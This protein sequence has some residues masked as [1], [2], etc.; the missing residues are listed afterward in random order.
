MWVKGWEQTV[1]CRKFLFNLTDAAAVQAVGQVIS[2]RFHLFSLCFFL[3]Y[4]MVLV[5]FISV[6]IGSGFKFKWVSGSGSRQ[7]IIVPEKE[8]ERIMFAE[9]SVGLDAFPGACMSF[10]GCLRRHLRRFL[11]KLIF[12]CH[13][14]LSVSGFRIQLQPGSGSG[15]SKM[16]GSGSWFS[17]SLSGFSESR[18]E[19]LIFVVGWGR[20]GVGWGGVGWGG[21]GWGG[22]GWG[23]EGYRSEIGRTVLKL[24]W[25]YGDTNSKIPCYFFH[26]KW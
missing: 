7:A 2:Q 15:F 21:V 11:I 16:S 20:V 22:V 12:H 19:T 17:E 6:L 25:F 5:Y 18:Y 26:V 3:T 23:W 4:N 10:V 9:F 14:H 8:I 13:C 1:R 24:H